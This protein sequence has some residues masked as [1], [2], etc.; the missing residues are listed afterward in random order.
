MT[1]DRIDFLR[2]ELRVDRQLM[3]LPGE[4]PHLVPVKTKTS[5]RTI[6]LPQVVIDA[7]AAHMAE[8]P[9]A[10]RIFPAI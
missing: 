2:R 1:R 4:T 8:F 5:M 6:P 9:T 7:L 3:N 10:D